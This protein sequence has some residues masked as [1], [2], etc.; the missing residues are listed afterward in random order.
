VAIAS[1]VLLQT[2]GCQ[3][4]QRMDRSRAVVLLLSRPVMIQ[5]L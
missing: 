5:H 3:A 4:G 1:E 2:V